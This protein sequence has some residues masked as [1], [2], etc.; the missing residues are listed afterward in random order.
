MSDDV[1]GGDLVFCDLDFGGVG[2]RVDAGVDVQSGAGG[3]RADQVD[4]D[5]VAGQRPPAPVEADARYL[6]SGASTP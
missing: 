6:G 1:D 4:D 2:G 3:G 5:L